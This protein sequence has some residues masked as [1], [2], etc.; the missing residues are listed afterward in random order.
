M[1]RLFVA[2]LPPPEA[3]TEI[4]T[5]V[6]P[7]RAGWPELR[8]VD[9]AL[10]H[11]TVAFLG[12]VPDEVLPELRVRLARAA[13]RHP[14][15]TVSFG[16]AGAFPSPAR[17][18]IFWLGLDAGPAL[19]RLAQSVAAGARRAGAE[20]TDRKR[21]HP[22]LT[23]ARSRARSGHGDD[24]RSLVGG[25]LGAFGGRRWEATSVHLVRSHTGATVRY[26]QVEAYALAVRG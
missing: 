11:V 1:S 26:E 10:W 8:W 22:H 2:L 24:L 7:V 4:A 20:E 3:L 13:A 9:P 12:E 6:E 18:R 23:L 25:A 5:A 14:A 16:G 21:F 19:T 17:G 15:Q